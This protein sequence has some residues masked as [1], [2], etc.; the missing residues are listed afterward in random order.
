MQEEGSRI[1]HGPLMYCKKALWEVIPPLEPP[2]AG[3]AL[4]S[5]DLN[6]LNADYGEWNSDDYEFR[7][8]Q[9]LDHLSDYMDT[10]SDDG[11]QGIAGQIKS[12]P[13]T[14]NNAQLHKDIC[15]VLK[16][17]FLATLLHHHW[18]SVALP[19]LLLRIWNWWLLFE[20]ILLSDCYIF[21]Q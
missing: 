13:K 6:F 1:R 8:P 15:E 14:P 16:F 9:D 21:K 18:V 19:T 2:L 5:I 20:R 12:W 11:S 10:L 7:Y 17:N 4:Q 3:L